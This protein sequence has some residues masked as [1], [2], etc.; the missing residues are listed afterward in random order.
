MKIIKTLQLP[1]GKSPFKDWLIK[2]N[3]KTKI[4]ILE[5]VNRLSFGGSK[6]NIKSVGDGLFE[7]KINFGAGYRVYFVETE[8]IIILIISGGDKSTQISDI[9]KAKE[10]WRKYALQNKLI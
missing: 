9:K 3:P 8:K 10:H 7:L 2:L 1:N 4:K 6:K 5:Y